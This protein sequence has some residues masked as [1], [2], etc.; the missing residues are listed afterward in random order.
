MAL[1]ARIAESVRNR[2][3]DNYIVTAIMLGF[4]AA[5]EQNLLGFSPSIPRRVM[6]SEPTLVSED[7]VKYL[8]GDK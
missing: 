7:L 4:V 6:K 5:V 2:P 3:R 8:G 1:R